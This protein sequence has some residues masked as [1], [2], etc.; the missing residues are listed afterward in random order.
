MSNAK[1]SCALFKAGRRINA[2]DRLGCMGDTGG[3]DGIHLH[4]EVI[5]NGQKIDPE[6]WVNFKFICGNRYYK[7]NHSPRCVGKKAAKKGTKKSRRSS[8]KKKRR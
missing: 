3:S 8:G 2:G 5:K 7:R 4:I 6:T 1:G